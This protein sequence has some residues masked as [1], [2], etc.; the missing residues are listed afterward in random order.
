MSLIQV[1]CPD[2][3]D[4]F[5]LIIFCRLAKVA[6]SFIIKLSRV[7]SAG[8][9]T[10]TKRG[11]HSEYGVW[12]GEREGKKNCRVPLA[13]VGYFARCIFHHENGDDV[14]VP[15]RRAFSEPHGVTTHRAEFFVVTAVC[16]LT[17]LPWSK[18][19]SLLL[20]NAAPPVFRALLQEAP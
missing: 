6:D 8:H 17:E 16:K 7:R 3:L 9:V 12:I 20:Q 2:R 18:T 1:T 19:A 4:F 13:S 15:K 5:K 11:I 10:G 14:M